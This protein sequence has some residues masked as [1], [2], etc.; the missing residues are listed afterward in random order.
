MISNRRGRMRAV[1]LH[2]VLAGCMLFGLIPTLVT[3]AP[4]DDLSHDIDNYRHITYTLARGS[5]DDVYFRYPAARAL[6]SP[7][8]S[9][10]DEPANT[11]QAVSEQRPGK[12]FL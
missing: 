6:S 12:T 5:H 10:G 11:Q 2:A 7:E 3:A 4:S 8:P 1:L 9:N